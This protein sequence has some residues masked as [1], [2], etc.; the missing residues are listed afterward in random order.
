MG[1][2]LLNF[3]PATKVP[4]RSRRLCCY[5]WCLSPSI[6]CYWDFPPFLLSTCKISTEQK[7][8][9]YII[10]KKIISKQK[11]AWRKKKRALEGTKLY[12]VSH[13]SIKLILLRALYT[14]LLTDNPDW[15]RIIGFSVQN[16]SAKDFCFVLFWFVLAGDLKAENEANSSTLC[17]FFHSLLTLTVAKCSSGQLGVFLFRFN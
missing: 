5:P 9:V 7:V 2:H 14:V 3:F 12:S 15:V 6:Q 4:A 1:A 17:C 13:P 11:F 16:F 8:A 10:M